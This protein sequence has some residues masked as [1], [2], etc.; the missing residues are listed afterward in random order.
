[1]YRAILVLAGLLAASAASAAD[2]EI[3]VLSNRADVISGD[4]ALVEVVLPPG[5]SAA[6][7][8]V[9]VDG[10][11]VSDQVRLRDN[12]RVM[13]LVTDL[14]LGENLLTARLADGRGARITLTNHPIGGPVFS[15]P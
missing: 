2:V 3:R 9:D 13:G 14:A 8:A 4:D 15:G 11:S 5:A 7:L 12:G 10:R 6:G 1:M